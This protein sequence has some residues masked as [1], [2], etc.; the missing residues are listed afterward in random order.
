MKFPV[1]QEE[2]QA[3][4]A[5]RERAPTCPGVLHMMA[6]GVEMGETYVV[7]PL[8][9]ASIASIFERLQNMQLEERWATVRVIGRMLL[10][11]LEGIHNCGIVHCDV[12]PNNIL[13]GRVDARTRKQ[14]AFRPFL[15][16]FGCA[17][18]FPGG[19]PMKG[20]WGSID[21][22]SIHSAGGG[23]RGPHDDLESLGWVLCH[24]LMGDLPWFKCTRDAWEVGMWK[25]E[26]VA[27]ACRQVQEAK[28]QVRRRGWGS[29]GLQWVHLREMP[30]ELNAFLQL[31]WKGARRCL[32]D[33]RAFA[34]LLG[35]REAVDVDEMEEIDLDIFN[36]NVV[37]LMDLADLVQL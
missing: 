4:Q 26:A 6:S 18:T 9:G 1:P 17:R 34:V 5:I 13:I 24:A 2:L 31:C 29:F 35:T 7:M 33:Y 37:P 30:A 15:T 23:E 14:A 10:R 20:T 36:E 32:P 12:Q 8:L 21:F 27:A 22:N 19:L 25:G 28:E 11:S 3:L 16:D